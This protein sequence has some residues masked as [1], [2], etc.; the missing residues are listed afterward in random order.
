MSFSSDIKNELAHFHAEKDCCKLAEIAGFIRMCGSIS[1]TGFGKFTIYMPADSPAIARHYKMLVKEYFDV[2]APIEIEEQ[3]GLKSGKEYILKIGPEENSEAILREIGIL[4]IK[5]GMNYFADGIYDGL[6]RTKCCRRSYLR[7]AFMAAGT[8]SNPEKGY[9]F[10]I[11]CSSHVLAQDIRKLIRT[12]TDLT[13]KIVVRKSGESVYIKSGTQILDLLSIMEAHGKRMD[14]DKVM[15]LKEIRN[16]TV[17]AINCDSANVD[18]IV[19]TASK[20]IDAIRKIERTRGLDSLSPKLKEAAVLRLE[21]P[22]ASFTEIGELMDPPVGR[23]GL[24]K[25]YRK[26]EEI[27]EGIKE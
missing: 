9:H 13:P 10:E 25:R 22:E 16:H 8:V 12:F 15:M 23:S 20:E 27:A 18:R 4:M 3:G 11:A 26:I 14:Y 7:G 5:G 24:S 6:I 2:D 21:N 19:K 17:R 1:L